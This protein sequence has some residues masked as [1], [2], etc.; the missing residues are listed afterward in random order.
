MQGIKNTVCY[1]LYCGWC[2]GEGK[3]SVFHSIQRQKPE[4]CRSSFCGRQ[5]ALSSDCWFRLGVISSQKTIAMVNSQLGGENFP[6]FPGP[7]LTSGAWKLNQI[8]IYNYIRCSS[9]ILH[10][11]IHPTFL[12]ATAYSFKPSSA[13]LFLRLISMVLRQRSLYRHRRMPTYLPPTHIYNVYVTIFPI[14]V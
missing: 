5:S 14:C 8:P 2:R 10:N 1:T 11:E 7:K 12:S 3:F 13:S 9:S 4:N 6:A